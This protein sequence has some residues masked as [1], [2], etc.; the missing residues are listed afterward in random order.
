MCFFLLSFGKSRFASRPKENN[1]RKAVTVKRQPIVIEQQ[2]VDRA[3]GAG[4][5][6]RSSSCGGSIFSK[7]DIS[8]R[9]PCCIPVNDKNGS[10]HY[11]FLFPVL[12]KPVRTRCNAYDIRIMLI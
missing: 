3:G 9:G 8:L 4:K 10:P 1:E 6:V 2:N 7:L 12:S 11:P 5:E